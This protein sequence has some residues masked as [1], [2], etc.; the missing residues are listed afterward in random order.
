MREAPLTLQ[1]SI[2]LKYRTLAST[3]GG[4]VL[5]VGVFHLVPL[6]LAFFFPH[7]WRDIVAF[8]A[9]A[10]LGIGLG[11]WAYLRWRPRG[12]AYSLAVQDGGILVVAVWGIAFVLGALPFW[13]SGRMSP[14]NALFES[15]SGWTTTGLSVLDPNEMPEAFLLW[16]SMTQFLGALG[17]ALIALAAI[18][19]TSAQS[20]YLAEGRSAL[21]LPN[22]RRT[23][24]LIIAMY[25]G[26]WVASTGL[27]WAG[28]MT[29]LDAVNHAMATVST[30]GFGTYRDS[31]AGWDSWVLELLGFILMFVAST[32][33]ATHFLLLKGKWRDGLRNREWRVAAGLLLLAIPILLANLASLPE[34]G[35][36]FRGLRAAAFESMAALSSTGFTS[37][38]YARWPDLSLFV[39][40]LL[41]LIGGGT[42]STAGGLKQYRVYLLLNTIRWKLRRRLLPR[43]AVV[44]TRAWTGDQWEKV[45]ADGMIDVSAFTLL[46]LLAYVAGVLVFLAYGYP[47]RESLFEMASSIGTTGLSVGITS[48]TAPAMIRVVEMVAM[49]LGRLEF[50]VVIYGA[51]RLA[52]DVKQLKQFGS[53]PRRLP[54]PGQ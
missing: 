52:G 40:T 3:I 39:L 30:G 37:T 27:Y 26:L 41:M 53:A 32:N 24:K 36:S 1:G 45:T 7:G 15:V 8:L 17:V 43:R 46:Y 28:G 5:L 51:L 29:F 23:A 42:G 50:F 14:L 10:A 9:P 2:R 34:Y 19:G 31:F 22:V 13:L 20:L 16:R 33:Y 47:L 18:I 6:V 49:A 25:L 4:I 21:L 38:T 48:A 11:A 35:W 54:D 44:E 12:E